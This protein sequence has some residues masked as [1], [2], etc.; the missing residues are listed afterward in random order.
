MQ[1]LRA[2]QITAAQIYKLEELWK[3]NPDATIEDIDRPGVDE[4]AQEVLL[5]YEDAYQYQNI[6]GPLV[7]MEADDDRKSKESQMLSDVVVR[8]DVGVNGKLPSEISHIVSCI[9]LEP[10]KISLSQVLF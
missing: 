7:K 9:C 1:E 2:R 4:E 8:W 10:L 6:F 3:D 5:R